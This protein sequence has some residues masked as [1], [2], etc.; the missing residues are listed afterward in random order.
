MA[1]T[2]E[3]H[4]TFTVLDELGTKA[5][6]VIYALADPTKTIANLA[7]DWETW[8]GLIDLII[9]GQILGGRAELVTVPSGAEKSSPAAGSRV[10]QTG[11]FDFPVTTTGKVFGEAVVSLA[12][13]V[14]VGGQ[15]DLTD[16][17][18]TNFYTAIATPTANTSPT[19]NTY[20]DLG[21]LRDAFISFRKHRRQLSRSSRDLP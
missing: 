16:T 18:V 7:A 15:I 8:A 2:Q 11:V 3:A 1:Y 14:I 5:S 20:Q 9:G 12:D 21:A 19:N 4:F 17:N 10:E 13:S 6:M